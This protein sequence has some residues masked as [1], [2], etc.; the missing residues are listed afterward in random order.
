MD[1]THIGELPT[2]AAAA[3][4]RGGGRIEE[5]RLTWTDAL[6]VLRENGIGPTQYQDLFQA[7]R[8]PEI[9]ER[10][11][12]Y[13]EALLKVQ[14]EYGYSKDEII[15]A[16]GATKEAIDSNI[17]TLEEFISA[18]KLRIQRPDTYPAPVGYAENVRA[19]AARIRAGGARRG[20]GKRKKRPRKS[21]KRKSK[22]RKSKKRKSKTRRRR[23]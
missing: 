5:N 21:K 12:A 4:E 15:G 23:R 2:N 10:R 11:D 19:E 1:L 14:K 7:P 22:K 13:L 18:A 9:V 3:S 8:Q 17:Q 16:L 6:S 20:G